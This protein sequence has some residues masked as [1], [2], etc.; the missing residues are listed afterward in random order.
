MARSINIDDVRLVL[1][2]TSGQEK[3][4]SLSKSYYKKAVGVLLVFSLEDRQSFE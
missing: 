1:W 4:R 2:D 3:F